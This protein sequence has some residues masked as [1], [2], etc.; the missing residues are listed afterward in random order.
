MPSPAPLKSLEREA[1]LK[2][3]TLEALEYLKNELRDDP[4]SSAAKL[5]QKY[6]KRHLKESLEK[7]RLTSLLAPEKELAEKGCKLIAGL[8]EA[9]RGPLVGPVVA[10]AVI[11]PPGLLM[12]G[13]DDSKKL[14]HEKRESLNLIIREKA[15]AWG[16][17]E[18]SA[19]EIDEINIYQAARL[20]MESGPSTPCPLPPTGSSPTPCRCPVI[21]TFPKR[22]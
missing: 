2:A 6:E 8:D 18:A 5:V 11:L 9:G 7:K 20:A 3:S 16:V 1:S 14:T 19:K 12:E 10:A 22:P 4:R 21:P 13:V 17:G 15:L